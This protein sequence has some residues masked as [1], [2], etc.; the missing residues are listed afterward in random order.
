LSTSASGA[1]GRHER[2]QDTATAHIIGSVI[3]K[4]RAN[5]YG[6]LWSRTLVILAVQDVHN[7]NFVTK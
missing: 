7:C 2:E 3:M 5:E 6:G 4:N 1:A